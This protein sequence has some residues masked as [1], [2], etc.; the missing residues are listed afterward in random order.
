MYDRFYFWSA[1]AGPWSLRNLIHQGH[2]IIL[3]HQGHD[4]NTQMGQT[5]HPDKN[6]PWFAFCTPSMHLFISNIS[7]ALELSRSSFRKRVTKS[8]Q[9]L[10]FAFAATTTGGAAAFAATAA[11]PAAVAQTSP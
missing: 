9:S 6:Y 1:H 7:L 8:E 3:A 11:G 4:I 10:S 5:H 2:N